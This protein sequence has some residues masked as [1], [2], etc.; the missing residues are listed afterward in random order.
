MANDTQP[1]THRTLL[2]N[3]IARLEKESLPWYSRASSVNLW[4]WNIFSAVALLCSIA[5]VVISGF[6]FKEQFATYGKEILVAV[7]ALGTLASGALHL[8]KFREKEILRETGRI[9]IQDAIDNAKSLMA[10]AQDEEAFSQAYHSVRARAKAIDE[11][12][13]AGDSKLKSDSLPELK[14]PGVPSRGDT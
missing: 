10:S 4:S 13:H 7:A 14:T 5:T 6:L 12:Q 2:R 11:S 9:E 1:E 3:L 8:F